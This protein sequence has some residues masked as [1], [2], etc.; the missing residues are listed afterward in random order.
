MGSV[1][2]HLARTFGN[3]P[4]R[5]AKHDLRVFITDIDVKTAKRK[6]PAHC[7]FANACGRM[8]QATKVLF[9][10]AMAYVDLPDENGVS[11]VERFTLPVAMRDFIVAF[12]KG[13]KVIPRGGFTLRA[14]SASK[15]LDAKLAVRRASKQRQPKHKRGKHAPIKEMQIDVRSGVGKVQ[16][17]NRPCKA[18]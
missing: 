10:R 6:D 11:H 4:V 1:R 16:F 2:K 12:D 15:T 9:L 13:E 8:F 5:D 14:P 3:L 7:V 18:A 17:A